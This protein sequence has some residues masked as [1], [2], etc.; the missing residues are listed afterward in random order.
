M[1]N[2]KDTAVKILQIIL[3]RLKKLNKNADSKF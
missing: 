1:W 3:P 2:L